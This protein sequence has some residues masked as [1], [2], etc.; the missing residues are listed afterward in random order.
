MLNQ[1]IIN[2]LTSKYSL[3]AVT[4][5]EKIEKGF[6]SENYKISTEDQ[7]FFLKKYRFNN[8]ERIREIHSVKYYFSENG[9]PVILPITNSDK[10]TFFESDVSY[11]ALFPFVTGIQPE[12]GTLTQNMIDSLGR[13]L[14][15]IHLAGKKCDLK[16]NDSFA[17]WNKQ[18]A[19]ETVSILENKLSGIVDKNSFDMLAEKNIK[20]KKRLITENNIDFSDLHLNIDHVIHGDYLDFNVFFDENENI[21]Y[22]FDFEK[23]EI[24]PRTHE[25]F[26]SATYSFLNTDFDNKSIK[27]IQV[28]IN[29][30]LDV[31]PMSKE[32]LK[33]G[34]TAHYFG[35]VHNFWVEKEHY[36]KNNQ[37]VDLF[38]ELN[39]KRLLF[40]SERLEEFLS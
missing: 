39:Y 36:L 2:I 19:L 21:K 27:N 23:T 25:L 22:V 26:R 30:Y 10:T 15:K 11:F 40:M 5:I 7:S 38:L 29:S 1:D 32:E 20:L 28:Y 35:S 6:L 17:E 31:Y 24:A 16:L 8:E 13:M 3:S 37:R 4:S 34:L 18:K 33:N 12:R 14:G 9:I